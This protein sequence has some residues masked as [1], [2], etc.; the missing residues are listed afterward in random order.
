[1]LRPTKIHETS[2]R[3]LRREQRLWH[4]GQSHTGSL[5]CVSCPEK[6]VCGGLQ[7]GR[8]FFDCLTNFCCGNPAKCDAVC[9]NRPD[10]FV[11]GYRE[12]GGFILDSV[13]RA[14]VLHPPPLP[15]IVPVLYNDSGR[16]APF[17]APAVCLPLYKV[18]QRH[19]GDVRYESAADL[20]RGFAIAPE[21]AVILTGTDRDAP[22]ERW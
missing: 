18:I 15:L 2:S 5:G 8:A 7:L 20:A 21:A 6:A 4:N 11:R 17:T 12:V 9:R 22:L 16:L 1:M 14:P 19:R 10:G 3:N 13:P